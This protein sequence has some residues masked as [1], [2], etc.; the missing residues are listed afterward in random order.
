MTPVS[1]LSLLHDLR[2]ATRAAHDELEQTAILTP[3]LSASLERSQYINVLT[4]FARF[5]QTAD[6]HLLTMQKTLTEHIPGYTYQP[7]L[8]YL[9]QDLIALGTQPPLSPCNI[10]APENLHAAIGWCY[11][12][13]GSSQGG[14]IITR[15]L[16]QTL[17]LQ[18]DSGLSFFHYFGYEHSGWDTLKNWLATHPRPDTDNTPA[19]SYSEGARHLFSALTTL[20]KESS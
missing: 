12:I 11:V 16:Q 6:H 2:D 15:R 4:M 17:A 9:Q 3:L 18:P 7:R 10:P 20:A 13:E 14:R 8:P 5:Y 1:S 19:S